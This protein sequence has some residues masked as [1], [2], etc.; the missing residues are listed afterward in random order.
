MKRETRSFD[1]PVMVA[2]VGRYTPAERSGLVPG[3]IVLMFGQHKTSALRED[4]D[5]LQ[6][7]GGADWLIL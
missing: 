1:E 7:I 3:D 4:P 6:R 2:A 5:L